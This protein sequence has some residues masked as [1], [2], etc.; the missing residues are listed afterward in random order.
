M[1]PEQDPIDDRLKSPPVKRGVVRHW[2][3]RLAALGDNPHRT[4]L[5]FAVG[6]FL[7]FS[8]FF[9]LQILLGMAIAIAF[10]LSRAAVLIGLCA[11]LPWIMI[12]WYAAATAAGATIL[13]F[14]LAADFSAR[15]ARLLEHP[16]YRPMFWHQAS[17][18]FG[19]LLWSFLLGSTAG[20]AVIAVTAY[21][22]MV[23]FL[24]PATRP[25]A[26]I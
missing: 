3:D 17:D 26:P 8:P 2:I 10:K 4:S 19:P 23:R 15:M 9:G 22:L 14:P 16:V 21:F 12:P 13:R 18:L 6:V 11:N 24:V 7:S 1:V 20:A 5:A 25:R